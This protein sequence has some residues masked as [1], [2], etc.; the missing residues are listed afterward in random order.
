MSQSDILYLY[1]HL[2]Q[3]LVSFPEYLSFP[4]SHELCMYIYHYTWHSL[5]TFIPP[6]T[7][8]MASSIMSKRSTYPITTSSVPLYS[9]IPEG[10][11][12]ERDPVPTKYHTFVLEY[13]STTDQV[14]IATM[15]TRP[16][17]L[18]YHKKERSCHVMVLSIEFIIRAVCRVVVFST[19]VRRRSVRAALTFYLTVQ[20]GNVR[21]ISVVTMIST[22]KVLVLHRVEVGVGHWYEMDRNQKISILKQKTIGYGD[23]TSKSHH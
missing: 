16:C 5:T 23:W 9:Y 2:H 4:P 21:R 22:V 7:R 19:L 11:V 1:K 14:S 12:A 17:V 15:M 10:L 6:W 20:N 13:L 18:E 3:D 8:G